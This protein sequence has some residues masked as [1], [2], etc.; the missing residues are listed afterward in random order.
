M[1]YAFIYMLFDLL[2]SHKNFRTF[3]LYPLGNNPR[4]KQKNR[5]FEKTPVFLPGNL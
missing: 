3:I 1:I 2:I 5:V 4:I